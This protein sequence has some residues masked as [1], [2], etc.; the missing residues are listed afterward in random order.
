MSKVES[1]GNFM[2]G[3]IA[4]FDDGQMLL[5]LGR[6]DGTGACWYKITKTGFEGLKTEQEMEPLTKALKEFFNKGQR[7]SKHEPL[8]DEGSHHD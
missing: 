1:V 2:E 5:R 7:T 8:H 3:L 4:E 6:T